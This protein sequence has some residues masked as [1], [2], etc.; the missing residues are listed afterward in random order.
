MKNLETEFVQ[1]ATS[2]G[3][4]IEK[5][6]HKEANKIHRKLTSV[7][8]EIQSKGESNILKELVGHSDESVK[9]WASTFLLRIDE[10]LALSTL[11]EISK[12]KKIFGLSASTTIDMWKKGMIK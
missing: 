7:F 8:K 12:S 3:N 5:G 6:E 11:N 2:H 4:A 10:T 9:L 1:L